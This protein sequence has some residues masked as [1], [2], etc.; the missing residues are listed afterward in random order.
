MAKEWFAVAIGG[1]LGVSAR[2][3]IAILVS[4]I[5]TAWI[6]IATLIANVC[7]CFAMGVLTQWAT[8]NGMSKEWWVVGC[9]VGVLGGLT[10]F[11]SFGLDLV[12]LWNESRSSSMLL[13]AAHL[14]LGILAIV[15]GMLMM[16]E[17]NPEVGS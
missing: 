16:Q 5:G 7:G 4:Q 17:T 15:A 12:K 6:P 2:H 3:L 14:A 8:Q 13:L 10:T 11:S 9:R 1:M